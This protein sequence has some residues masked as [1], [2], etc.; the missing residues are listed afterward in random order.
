M[1]DDDVVFLRPIEE[2]DLDELTRLDTD[3]SVSEPFEW[4]GFRDPHA[5]RRRWEKDGY[6]GSE[7]S[8]LVVSLPDGTFTGIVAWRTVAPA[9]PWGCL[10]I[11]I[12]LYPDYRGRGLGTAAQRL[13]ATYLF[14]NTTVHRLE[15]TNEL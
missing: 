7:E 15:A 4:L 11:G 14:A 3:P 10:E 5:K 2:R 9:R 6:L 13:L 8:M 1:S 12:L